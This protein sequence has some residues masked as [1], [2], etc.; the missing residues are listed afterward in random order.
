MAQVL[1]G[2]EAL[3]AAALDGA[4]GDA[5]SAPLVVIVAR[6]TALLISRIRQV[7]RHQGDARTLAV[8]IA[9]DAALALRCLAAGAAGVV[10]S[11]AGRGEL[12]EAVRNV[13]AGRIHVPARARGAEPEALSPREREVHALLRDRLTN[14]EIALRLRIE[15]RTVKN[16]VG[17]VLRKLG[18]RSRFEAARTA[19][20][21]L[22]GLRRSAV[23]SK[24]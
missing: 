1:P 15:V 17:H 21:N 12:R 24:K 19:A 11:P 9:D 7:L 14:K 20:P 3:P 5:P 18:I 22:R 4:L 16:H 6:D 13:L 8:G 10:P 2:A 23:R